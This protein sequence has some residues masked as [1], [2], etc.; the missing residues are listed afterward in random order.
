VEENGQTRLACDKYQIINP[1]ACPGVEGVICPV[2][3]QEG[4]RVSGQFLLEAIAGR[5]LMITVSSMTKDQVM[6]EE[7][8]YLVHLVCGRSL[9]PETGDTIIKEE[10]R[11]FP[12]RK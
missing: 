4:Q 3:C 1:G 2:R 7:A 5:R 6:R 11:K 9:F 12:I 8:T 10:V